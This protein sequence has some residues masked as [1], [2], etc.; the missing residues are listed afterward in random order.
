MD[1]TLAPQGDEFSCGV[2]LSC[3]KT[4]FYKED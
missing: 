3:K 2:S 1:V 4:L